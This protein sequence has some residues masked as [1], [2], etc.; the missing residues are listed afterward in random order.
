M[1]RA[2]FLSQSSLLPPPSDKDAATGF[3][4]WNL[5]SSIVRSA[6]SP[7]SFVGDALLIPSLQGRSP[8]VLG[9]LGLVLYLKVFKKVRARSG[10]LRPSRACCFAPRNLHSPI[11]F[12]QKPS[13]SSKGADKFDGEDITRMFPGGAAGMSAMMAGRSAGKGGLGGGASDSM[14]QAAMQVRISSRHEQTCAI[15]FLLP[16]MR[17]T[18]QQHLHHEAFSR[19]VNAQKN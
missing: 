11:F 6:A 10:S 3:S 17:V 13:K 18:L 15:L 5:A 1:F 2:L 19:R 14:H 8:M 4:L 12:L 7:A 9:G 16:C